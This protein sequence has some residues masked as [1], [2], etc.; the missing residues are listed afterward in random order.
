MAKFQSE[1]TSFIPQSSRNAAMRCAIHL[2]LFSFA[3]F[4]D[5]EAF[6]A[7]LR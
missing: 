4:A 3:S 2:F 5:A 7:T 1:P 6:R